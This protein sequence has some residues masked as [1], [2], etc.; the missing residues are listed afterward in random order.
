[1]HPECVGDDSAATSNDA[2]GLAAMIR[3]CQTGTRSVTDKGRICSAERAGIR[4]DSVSTAAG[5]T[6]ERARLQTTRGPEAEEE[7]G[8]CDAVATEE[9]AR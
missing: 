1:M 5:S 4:A 6:V 3:S 2:K 7:E 9:I 8:H